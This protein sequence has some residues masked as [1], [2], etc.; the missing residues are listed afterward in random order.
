MSAKGKKS[1]GNNPALFIS[2]EHFKKFLRTKHD[3]KPLESVEVVFDKVLSQEEAEGMIGNVTDDE[4]KETF[5]E[6][7]SN[8]ASGLDGYTSVLKVDIPNKVFEFRPIAFCNVIYKSISKILTNRI[9]VGLQKEVNINQ[10]VFILG[11]HI[12]DNILIAQELLK[13]YQ[14]K[15][16]AKRCALKIDIQKAYDS[17]SWFS[18]CVNGYFEGGRGLRQGYPIS[19]YLFTLVMEV[20]SLLLSSNI[21]MAKKFKF[22]Y[23]CKELKLSNMCFGDDLLVLCN[24][25][26]DTVD[27]YWAS[28]YML[29]NSIITEIE[30]LLKGFLWCQGPLNSGKAKVAWKQLW[31]IIDRKESLWVKW[32]IV[33]KLKGTII[34]DIDVYW[35]DNQNDKKEFS[36]KQVWS[37]LGDI[38]EKVDWC[39]VVWF[40]Q[41]QPRHAFMLWLVIKERLSTQDRLARWNCQANVECPL[42]KKEKDSHA[43]L[44]F[45]CDFAEQIWDNLKMKMGNL[46]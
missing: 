12:Q 40:K 37:D 36:T 33:V 19:P 14:R 25:Y 45:K 11:R 43:H 22:H 31:K 16:G 24:G 10:S 5:F 8:K 28:I 23:G 4:I 15:K 32:V 18:I 20:F 41:F 42:C 30:K 26:M 21:Q 6:I 34:W 46:R 27:I 35:L 3:V 38:N 9:K 1:V 39:H 17:I 2:I 29:P 44:F 13:G 7:D